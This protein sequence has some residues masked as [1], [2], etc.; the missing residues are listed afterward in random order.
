MTNLTVTEPTTPTHVPDFTCMMDA[1]AADIHDRIPGAEA[2]GFSSEVLAEFLRIKAA[3]FGF[4]GLVQDMHDRDRR[5]PNTSAC[6]PSPTVV[7]SDNLQELHRLFRSLIISNLNEPD[8]AYHLQ[9][10]ASLKHA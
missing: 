6:L 7:L 10:T 4:G 3:L 2:L 1:V 5:L 8:S 9:V